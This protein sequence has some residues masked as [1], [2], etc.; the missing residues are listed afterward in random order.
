[1]ESHW[2][3]LSPDTFIFIDK[4]KLLLYNAATHRY[5]QTEISEFTHKLYGYFSVLDNLY[6]IK[7]SD[8]EYVYNKELLDSI[9][10]NGFG[11]YQRATTAEKILSYPPVCK[12]HKDIH[13]IRSDYQEKRAGYILDYL[14]EITIYLT[15]DANGSPDF[16][17]QTIYPVMSDYVIKLDVIM[18]FMKQLK[19]ASLLAMH[20][21]CDTRLLT[22]Y[23][24][25]FQYLKQHAYPVHFYIFSSSL[26]QMNPIPNFFEEINVSVI[27]TGKQKTVPYKPYHYIYLITD[28]SELE[29]ALY[30]SSLY[31]NSEI[32]P[33]YTGNNLDFFIKRVFTSKD[34]LLSLQLT[35]REIFA[36]QLLNT[37]FFGK[38]TLLPD[39]S[40]YANTH[41]TPLGSIN[42]SL[43]EV[44]FKA[45]NESD[46]WMMTRDGKEPCSDCRFRYLCPP[47]S[48]YE[49]FIGNNN[50][51]NIWE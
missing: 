2:L 47:I 5:L 7:L 44:I 51:C 16:Y 39:S 14:K 10:H 24:H 30:Q 41:I 45:L 8:N 23:T 3:S 17:R 22:T 12:I 31:E 40:V 26:D 27:C 20:I 38:L 32:V 9:H 11:K 4:K 6:N 19:G 29:H 50:L 18:N 42:D 13:T 25:F 36:R 48:N 21:L 34:E 28:E 1:M 33:I 35:K 43:Y 37:N 46:S 49:L 15:G